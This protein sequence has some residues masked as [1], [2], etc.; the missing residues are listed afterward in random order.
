VRQDQFL[1]LKVPGLINILEGVT[2]DKRS[3]PLYQSGPRN[4]RIS[5]EVELPEGIKA[6]EL[7]PPD[8]FR[9]RM[10]SGGG[11]S[12]ETSVARAENGKK[13]EIVRILQDV[14]IDPVIVPPADY[15]ELLD[16]QR[17]ISHPSSNLILMRMK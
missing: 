5:V 4:A 3:N 6:C 2:S 16:S 15:P 12:M 1:Y 7:L 11:I 9:V 14:D 17:V 10:G 13:Y 8:G